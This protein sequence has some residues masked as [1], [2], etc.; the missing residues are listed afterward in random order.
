MRGNLSFIIR[1]AHQKRNLFLY[2]ITTMSFFLLRKYLLFDSIME[3]K[4]SCP[5]FWFI[6]SDSFHE[7]SIDPLFKALGRI[8]DLYNHPITEESLRAGYAVDDTIDF[9][10]MQRISRERLKLEAH[11]VE[12]VDLPTI[13][14][15]WPCLLILKNNKIVVLEE[16]KKSHAIVFDPEN[17]RQTTLTLKALS[18]LYDGRIIHFSPIVNLHEESSKEKEPFYD[19]WLLDV[20]KHFKKIYAQVV[21]SAFITNL[22]ALMVPLFAMNVYDRV[23]PNASFSTLWVLS[24]G[25]LI[26]ISFDFILKTLKSYLVD[27]AGKNADLMFSNLLLEKI[28]ALK[29]DKHNISSGMM[30]SYTRELETIR[31]FFSSITLVTLIDIPFAFLFLFIIGFIGGPLLLSIEVTAILLILVANYILH[32]VISHHTEHAQKTVH[33]K[34]NFLV[35]SILGLETIKASTAEAKMQRQWGV[36]SEMSAQESKKSSFFS[37]LAVNIASTVYNLSYIS[38]VIA[39]VYLIIARELTMGGLIA[40]SILSSRCLTPFSQAVSV[41]LR[42]SHVRDAYKSISKLMA[43]PTERK[44]DFDYTAKPTLKGSIVFRNVSFTYPDQSAPALKNVSFQINPGD[45]IAILGKIGSG[46][47]TIEKLILGFYEPTEGEIIID[48]VDQRQIDPV[49]FRSKINHVP[50]NTYLFSGTLLE[51]IILSSQKTTKE[52]IERTLLFSGASDFAFHHPKGMNMLIKDSGNSL[53]GGQKQAVC[54]ARAF[55]KDAPFLLLDEPTSMMDIHTEARFINNLKNILPHKT[56]I[57]VSHNLNLLQLVDKV[58]VLEQGEVNFFGTRHDFLAKIQEQQHPPL[59]A[60]HA[61]NP[62]PQGG[63][64]S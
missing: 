35:E 47:T 15:A 31:E 42:F 14:E 46:K 9:E 25:I 60:V 23:I 53:S 57:L 59:K 63:P 12:S 29:L 55:I 30:L 41:L 17:P 6:V 7:S 48:G 18:D 51:N 13:K 50:Q 54:I 62:T 22:L 56:M 28:F 1:E 26:A 49:D 27:F 10:F 40:C 61:Q 43:M 45:K 11:I 34:N 37:S 19:N 58:L 52:D 38:I 64:K 36:L 32:K 3:I 5:K 21:F 20:L 44:T 2:S 24:A 33:K 16:I 4:V 8:A 39:G